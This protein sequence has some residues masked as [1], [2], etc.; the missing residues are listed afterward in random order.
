VVVVWL[1]SR[2]I[3]GTLLW[4]DPRGRRQQNPRRAAMLPIRAAILA[5]ATPP[6]S[7]AGP[8]PRR[9][10]SAR[11]ASWPA[12]AAASPDPRAAASANARCRL[13]PRATASACVHR[14]PNLCAVAPSYAP[15]LPQ[16]TQV[17]GRLLEK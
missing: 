4:S 10:A 5:S 12:H 9:P 6:C 7:V 16:A 11:A 1:R 3:R 14:H 2:P 8:A 17:T 13:D 15:L